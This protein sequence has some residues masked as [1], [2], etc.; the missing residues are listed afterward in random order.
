MRGAGDHYTVGDRI[1]FYRHRRGLTQRV[2]ADLV[3]RSEDWLSKIERNKRE[4]RRLDVL[5][6]VASALRVGIGDLL[7]Q[8]VLVEDAQPASPSFASV[9]AHRWWMR[10][11]TIQGR[12]SSAGAVS[13]RTCALLIRFGSAAITRP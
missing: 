8:P 11:D 10:P 6:E 1:A 3:G 13:S 12:G 4:I 5:A 2:V 9:V 7:G